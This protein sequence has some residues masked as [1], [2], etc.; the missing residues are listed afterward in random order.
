MNRRLRAPLAGALLAS[1]LL[2]GCA[3][4]Y[5]PRASPRVQMVTENGSPALV[6]NGQ[7]YSLGVFGSNLEDVVAGNPEAEAEARS[8]HTKSVT[9]FVLSTVGLVSAG[10]GTGFLVDNELSSNPSSSI[11]TGSLTAAL[12]G[13]VLSIVGSAVG[14]SAQPHLW[15]AINLYNDGLPTAPAPWAG[16]GG[17]PGYP[18]APGAP[19][20]NVAPLPPSAIPLPPP[21]D[22]APA[23]PPVPAPR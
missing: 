21:T 10:L 7:S 1:P 2:T 16:R 13:L 15:N 4:T 17:Y 11:R 12:G 9:G 18:G 3:T 22:L 20:Y 5:L 23:P 14:G 19:G 6:K 8:Y